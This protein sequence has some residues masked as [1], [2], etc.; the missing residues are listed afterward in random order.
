MNMKNYKLW[1]VW[2]LFLIC[3]PAMA[4]LGEERGEL[5]VGINGGINMSKVDFNPRIKQKNQKKLKNT[6]KTL[7]C[8]IQNLN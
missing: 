8:I 6:I 3:T 4:Q 1:T 2:V 7:T 5:S